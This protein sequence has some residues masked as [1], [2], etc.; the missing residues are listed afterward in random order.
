[1][2]PG[3]KDAKAHEHDKGIRVGGGGCSSPRVQEWMLT[4]NSH[5][6]EI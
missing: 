3:T 4:M 1:M 6:V 2:T 5:R